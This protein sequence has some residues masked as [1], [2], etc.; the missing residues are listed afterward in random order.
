MSRKKVI[1]DRIREL[2]EELSTLNAY[3]DDNWPKNTVLR[4]KY[5]FQEG[6]QFYTYVALKVSNVWYLTGKT[7]YGMTWESFVDFL[8]NANKVK[9]LKVATSWVDV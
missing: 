9:G 5:Q 1:K 2:E 8:A 3:G 6:G 7:T 4:F